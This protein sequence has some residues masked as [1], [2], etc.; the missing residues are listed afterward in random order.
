MITQKKLVVR[1]DRINEPPSSDETVDL[2]E[3]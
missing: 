3:R 2:L 1:V